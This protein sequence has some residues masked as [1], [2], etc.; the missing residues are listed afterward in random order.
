MTAENL[1]YLTRLI[2][3]THEET[4]GAHMVEDILEFACDPAEAINSVRTSRWRA[5]YQGKPYIAQ[6]GWRLDSNPAATFW[7]PGG[8]RPDHGEYP[9]FPR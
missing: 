4:S 1:T 3:F 6:R 7:M 2:F 5:N 8:G 9:P